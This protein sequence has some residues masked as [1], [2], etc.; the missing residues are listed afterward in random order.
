MKFKSIFYLLI[1]LIFSSGAG[2]CATT[3]SDTITVDAVIQAATIT[4][5]AT[6]P[7]DFGT[8]INADT[9]SEVTIDASAGAATPSVTSGNG[10]ILV[11]GNNGILVVRTNIDAT[12]TV[13][14]PASATI[15]DGGTP[16]ST[17]TV[18]QI[19]T[20]S[21]ASPI[22][23]TANTD[24]PVNI[25]GVLTVGANQTAA[26]YTGTFSVTVSY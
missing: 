15:S 23:T 13:S 2:Y 19:G 18:D 5:T 24:F 6:Q 7:L 26:T 11:A 12:I 3:A 20:N 1:T 9:V 4:A 10:S 16:A 8:I 21:T 22:S 17:M 25:G 14:Y